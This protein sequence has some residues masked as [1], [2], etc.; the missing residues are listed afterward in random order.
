MNINHDNIST[1]LKKWILNKYVLTCLVFA[2][3][4]VF[5]GE[6]SLVNRV[7]RA[8]QISALEKERDAIK[9]QSEKYK[10][11]IELLNQNTDSLERFARE[12]YYMHTDNETVYLIEE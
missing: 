12:H 11:D 6:Q 8:A 3:I 4:M 9:G 7:R 2:V 10:H 1:F 5:F